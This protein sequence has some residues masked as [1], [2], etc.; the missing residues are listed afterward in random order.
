MLNAVAFLGVLTFTTALGEVL[1]TEHNATSYD[2]QR[3]LSVMTT[4]AGRLVRVHSCASAKW[5]VSEAQKKG[6]LRLKGTADLCLRGP[7]AQM[8]DD[9]TTVITGTCNSSENRFY[10]HFKSS[11]KQVIFCHPDSTTAVCQ[12]DKCLQAVA[13]ATDQEVQRKTCNSGITGQKW[14]IADVSDN[15]NNVYRYFRPD[16]NSSLC[17]SHSQP[18]GLKLRL[19]STPGAGWEVQWKMPYQPSR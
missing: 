8:S 6:G 9:N 14:E 7:N 17:L 12:W 13:V 16:S 1:R 10:F 19:C 3:A 4:S 18:A 15:L 2:S 5:S 11:T